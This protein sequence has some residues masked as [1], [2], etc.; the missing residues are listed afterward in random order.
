MQHEPCSLLGHSQSAMQFPR[1]DTILAVA[2]HPECRHPL[3]HAKRGI[4][5]N[6]PNLQGEL[7]IA[8]IAKPAAIAL[9]ERVLGAATTWTGDLAIRPAQVNGILESA[10]GVSEVNQSLLQCL[11]FDHAKSI[12]YTN[13]FVKNISALTCNPK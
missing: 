4:L 10:F 5:E 3:I 2:E 1:R 13:M 8:G 9:D 7:A 6:R 12:S 11:W